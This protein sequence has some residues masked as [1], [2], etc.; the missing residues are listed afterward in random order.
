MAALSWE[1]AI[2]S[3]LESFPISTVKRMNRR[4]VLQHCYRRKTCWFVTNRIWL[5]LNFPTISANLRVGE[6][7]KKLSRYHCFKLLAI[8][9]KRMKIY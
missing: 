5:N 6:R 2:E 4:K 3:A 1:E 9:V 7:Q 8:A